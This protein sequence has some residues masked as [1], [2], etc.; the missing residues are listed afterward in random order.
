M[1]DARIARSSARWNARALWVAEA[2]RITPNTRAV[3]VGMAMRSNRR[4]RTRQ[5]LR[6]R[7]DGRPLLRGPLVP[8]KGEPTSLP[9]SVGSAA[10]STGGADAPSSGLGIR[11]RLEVH[12]DPG[13]RQSWISDPSGG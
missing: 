13:L 5:S 1:V 6:R 10:V 7:R 12:L 4:V 9:V 11:P 3:T 2:M 8:L